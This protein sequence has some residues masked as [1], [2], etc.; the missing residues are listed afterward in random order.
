MW[1]DK[2]IGINHPRK[3]VTFNWHAWVKAFYL[4]LVCGHSESF[5]TKK[6]RLLRFRRPLRIHARN[7]KSKRNQNCKISNSY[8][9]LINLRWKTEILL[10][11][12]VPKL[13]IHHIFKGLKPSS[14]M[15]IKM[16][17]TELSFFLSWLLIPIISKLQF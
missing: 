17:W 3:Q 16:N 9:Q 10:L 8:L 11:K 15:Q 13:H 14:D 4:T 12:I 1:G 7:V 6:L 2:P 5:Q